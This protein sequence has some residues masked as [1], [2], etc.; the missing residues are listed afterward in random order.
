MEV[1]RE[2][3]MQRETFHLTVNI[4]DRFLSTVSEVHKN[5]LQLVG[6]A[7]LFVA[8][9]VHPHMHGMKHETLSMKHEP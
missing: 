1:C 9:K 2:F 5:R 8:A 3:E 7:A 4:V 6:V